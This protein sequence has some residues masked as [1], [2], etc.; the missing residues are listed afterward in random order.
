MNHTSHSDIIAIIPARGGSKSIPRKNIRLLNGIPLIVYSIEAALQ[1]KYISRIIVSTDDVTIAEIARDRGAETPFLRPSHLADDDT[2]DLPVFRHALDFLSEKENFRP[3][4][5]VQLRPTSPFRPPGI[6]DNA[7]ELILAN[8]LA[9][10]IRCVTP[11]GENPFKMWR[12]EQGRL[13]PLLHSDISEPYNMPRQHLPE[14]FW[15]TGLVE[16]IRHQTI[17][18]KLSMTGEVILPVLVPHEYAVDIDNDFQW[19]WAEL[20]LSHG[21]LNLILP[22]TKQERRQHN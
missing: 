10:S 13:L 1:S 5:I 8:P 9:D 19:Q 20:I 7:I 16:V 18:R 14:T 21:N 17:T 2:T 12:I 3:E 11:A 6:I 22:S 4:L 15:Q